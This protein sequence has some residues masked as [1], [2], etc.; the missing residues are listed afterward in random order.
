MT[1][2]L[3]CDNCQITT[4]PIITIVEPE[5]NSNDDNEWNYTEEL[6]TSKDLGN[7]KIPDQENICLNKKERKETVFTYMI[8]VNIGIWNN[9]FIYNIEIEMYDMVN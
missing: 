8:G 7:K 3:T 6:I 1:C 4:A 9:Y 5:C 2:S